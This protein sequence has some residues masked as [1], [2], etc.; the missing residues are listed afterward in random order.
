MEENVLYQHWYKGERHV[1]FHEESRTF[2]LQNHWISYVMRILPNGQPGQL[3]FGKRIRDR[4]SFDHLLEGAVRSHTA[5]PE[6]GIFSL[7][8]VK[9]EYLSNFRL[10]RAAELLKLTDYTIESIAISCGYRDPLVF[11][12]AFKKK[13]GASPMRYRKTYQLERLDS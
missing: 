10:T 9:Q 4:K 2:H 11:A 6:D 13:Y 1:F 7:E 12:K 3:Y 5:Y 8:H